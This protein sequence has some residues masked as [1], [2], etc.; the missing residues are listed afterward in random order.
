MLG[1]IA[2]RVGCT[3]Q[4]LLNEVDSGALV[5]L[6]LKGQKAN[7]RTVRVPIECYRAW[8]IKKLTGDVDIKMQFLRDLPAATRSE[9]IA[10]LKISLKE[11][12]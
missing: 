5:V 7:R 12:P 8:V 2:G 3:G 6:D 9:L 11:N 1:E 10:A 4:H